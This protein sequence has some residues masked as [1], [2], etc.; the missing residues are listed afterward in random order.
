M[1]SLII[2]AKER[3]DVATAY[4]E[5]AYLQT[6]MEDFTLLKLVGEAVDIMCKVNP[7]YEKFVVI[8]NGKK[9]L[10]L[11]LLKALY[12]CVESA[13][14]W[15][16]LFT[17]TLVHMG[18][19]LK[20]YNLCVANSQ[21]KRKQCTIAWYVDDNK[22]SR[23]DDTVVTDIIEKIKAKFGKMT[24]T[25][26][27]HHV[28][29]G[30][31]ITFN[32]NN[33]TV[34]ILMKE[35]LKEAIADSGMDASKVAPTPAKK[36]LFTVDDGSEQHDKRQGEI[37]RSIVAKLLY[38]AKRARTDA[39]LA[40][41]F[42]CTR[43]PCSTEQDWKELIRLLQYFNGTLDMPLILGADS[44]AESKLWVDAAY[45]VHDD[46]K[47][48][49]GGA[50]S[51]GRGAIM[52]KSTKQKLNTK[53]STEANVV[54]SSDYLPNTIWGRM[55]LAK[56]GYK[57]TENIF[58]QDNQSAIRLEKNGRASCGQK[59]RHIDIRNFFMQ[60]RFEFE[61]I[62]AVY[63]PTDEMLANFFMKPLQ[64]S[65]FWKFRAVLLGHCHVNTLSKSPLPP[66]EERVE[67]PILEKV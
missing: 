28:I 44:L 10:Y 9:V 63:C 35:Y 19:K 18:F 39:Q 8:E 36:D 67:N 23:V 34:T 52:C 16:N 41:A 21:I 30:M 13:L 4:V 37:F 40:I 45:A 58:Y 64:G 24:V 27:K 1:I 22:I 55:F 14:L 47:S 61:S 56:Q 20:S 26:G 48:H 54:C 25:R 42:L 65:L 66:S 49:T 43:V 12:G 57:L 62:S 3:R 11:Q 32:N 59:S 7:K 51:L 53:S 31:D 60:D 5:G 29:L 17:N 50:T 33:G 2:D 15:Y 46:M 38:V 6:D